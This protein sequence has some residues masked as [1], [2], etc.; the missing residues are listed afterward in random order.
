MLFV[1]LLSLVSLFVYKF[2]KS[3]SKKNIIELNLK[4]YN[5]SSHPVSSKIFATLLYLLE[6]AIIMP[7]LLMLWFAGLAIV[8]LL[9]APER[10][11]DEIVFISA[12]LVAT[13]R[14]LAYFKGEISKDLA[15]LFPFIALSLFLLSP[16]VFDLG[17]TIA[18]LSA[19]PSVLNNLFSFILVIFLLEIFLRVIYAIFQFW[20]SEEEKPVAVYSE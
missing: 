1:F 13:I 15:K 2:Y 8:L 10:G 5:Y 9:I 19:I 14:V 12:A 17:N 3:T 16:Q 18:Q 20:K 11:A 7:F 4:K 6:Y